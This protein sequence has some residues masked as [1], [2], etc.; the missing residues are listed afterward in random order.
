MTT[1]QSQVAEAVLASLTT[2]SSFGQPFLRGSLVGGD[3][4]EYA[5]IDIGLRPTALT[6]TATVARVVDIMYS[7][8]EV[9]FHDWAR[10]LLPEAA[11]VS[12][13]LRDVPIFWNVDL[14]VVVP[15]H[16]RTATRENVPHDPTA[17]DLK[18]WPIALKYSLR[19]SVLHMDDVTRFVSRYER[20]AE[21]WTELRQGLRT[22][23]RAIE[24]DA[25]EDYSPFISRCWDTYESHVG[26]R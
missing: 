17:H 10:S 24:S 13:F 6:D 23:L 1:T 19:E 21:G 20:S 5:D 22:A 2:E 15:E 3:L 16:F 11:V 14:E 26:L 12:F 8:H 25:G 18:I 9:E 7:H 4:D